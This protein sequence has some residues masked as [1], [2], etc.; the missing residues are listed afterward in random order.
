MTVDPDCL[1]ISAMNPLLTE[2]W[3]AA[4]IDA[5]VAPY[6]GRLSEAQV[7]WMREQLAEVLARDESA[8]RLLARALPRQVDE[9]GVVPT[10]GSPRGAAEPIVQARRRKGA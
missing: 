1:T 8:A 10:V 4:Q 2:S 9:S 5:A 7:E 3:V 6:R